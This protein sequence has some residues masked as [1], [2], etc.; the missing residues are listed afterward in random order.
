MKGQDQ[1]KLK[2]RENLFTEK[3]DEGEPG[4]H[5]VESYLDRLYTLMMAYAIAEV[6][7]PVGTTPDTTK[8]ATWGPR[9]FSSVALDIYMSY[10]LTKR[11]IWLQARGYDERAEWTSRF[12]ESTLTLWVIDDHQEGLSDTDWIPPVGSEPARTS[13]ATRTGCEWKRS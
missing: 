3:V 13:A 1:K 7:A 9:E 2:L 10:W 4:Q 6:S 11:L 5:N 12:R 8:E